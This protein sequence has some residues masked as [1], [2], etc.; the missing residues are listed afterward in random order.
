MLRLYFKKLLLTTVFLILFFLFY[1]VVGF[2]WMQI[3]STA[4]FTL[5]PNLQICLIVVITLAIELLAVYFLRIDNPRQKDAFDV[6]KAYTFPAD[7]INTLKSAENKMH[8]FAYVTLA[9]LFILYTLI[10]NTFQ[11]STLIAAIIS[12][13]LFTALNTLLW[14]IIHKR[15]IVNAE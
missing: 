10:A 14:S 11:L 15:W 2:V 5:H 9:A 4:G 12:C 6:T 7:F 1:L 13:G 3:A 8:T